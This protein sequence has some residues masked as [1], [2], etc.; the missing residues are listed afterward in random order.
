MLDGPCLVNKGVKH[1]MRECMGLAKALLEEQNKKHDDRDDDAG[2][3]REPL[4][5]RVVLSKALARPS[6]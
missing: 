5:M 4:G 2:K 6:I 1:T 3:D